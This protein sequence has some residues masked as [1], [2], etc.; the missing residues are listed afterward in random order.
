M[1]RSD[2][3]RE[4]RA[5]LGLV[6]ADDAAKILGCTAGNVR[7]M[8]REGKLAG[9]KFGFEIWIDAKSVA[10]WALGEPIL[11]HHAPSRQPRPRK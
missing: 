2:N 6:S 9:R 8:A 10:D 7:R 5:K 3:M 4:V 1:R 11:A